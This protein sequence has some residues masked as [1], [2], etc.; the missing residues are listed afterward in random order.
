MVAQ[1]ST[2]VSLKYYLCMILI[3]YS[4]KLDRRKQA[5]SSIEWTEDK[6]AKV[7]AIL[8]REC[9]SSESEN[10]DERESSSRGLRKRHT[11]PMP[12]LSDE[13]VEIKE[14]LDIHHRDTAS[15]SHLRSLADIVTKRPMPSSIPAWA[16]QKL[17]Y[18]FI[19]MFVFSVNKC[20]TVQHAKDENI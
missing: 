20:F 3:N 16:I 13:C 12:W 5:L 1:R 2:Y 4:I 17:K 19:V 10:E 11:R 7:Q 14:H 9:T 18:D 15:V 8:C 6:I